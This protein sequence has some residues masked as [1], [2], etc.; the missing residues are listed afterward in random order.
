MPS[1]KGSRGQGVKGFARAQGSKRI[2]TL[3]NSQIKVL[4]ILFQYYLILLKKKKLTPVYFYEDL[5]LDETRQQIFTETK[6]LIAI[7]LILNKFTF[8][9]K[10]V[11][12]LQENFLLDFLII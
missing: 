1:V 12:L 8:F 9:I 2:Q 10:L 3:T 11:Q 4:L 6:G 5:H 7:Y